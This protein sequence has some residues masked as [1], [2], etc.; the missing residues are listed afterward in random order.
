VTIQGV[1]L[2]ENKITNVD[3]S[4]VH[5]VADTK[6]G[7]SGSCVFNN[8]WMPF[9]LHHASAD[10]DPDDLNPSRYVNEGIR[11]SP[12]AAYLE[13]FILDDPDSR[14]AIEEILSHVNGT[15]AIL[16]HWGALGRGGSNSTPA[17]ETLV[18]IYKG[19]AGDIDVGF[20]NIEWFNLHYHEK[21]QRVADVLVKMNLDIWA[22][23]ET[24]AEA[25]RALADYLRD[26]YHLDFG[27]DFSEPDAPNDKQTTAV[28]W[29][30][31]TVEGRKEQWPDE[32][33]EWFDVHS[34][35]FDDLNLEAVDGK[36]FDRYSAFFRF[37]NKGG[38]DFDFYLVPLHLKAKGEGQKRRRMAAAILGAAVSAMIE[39]YGADHD[40]V[41]GGD[42]DAPLA[43]K[44]FSKLIFG[45]MV[46][47]SAGNEEDGAFSYVKGPQSLIDHIFLSP[48]L[49]QV[50]GGKDF[51]IVA[52]DKQIPHYLTS[53]SDHRAVLVR[54]SINSYQPNEAK[55]NYERR[56]K[57]AGVI[58]R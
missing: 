42:F 49:A 53:L 9:A 52:R 35:D 26:V 8:S 16:G 24:S 13:K 3:E 39:K 21:L 32:I 47:L 58:A 5:Y 11:F 46:P 31:K 57:T 10:N 48:N 29:N 43:S 37:S 14:D 30:R 44:D 54:L 28:I 41:I 27:C 25:T 6:P 7:S 22:F 12:I 17:V 55:R 38:D 51:F 2:Q 20:W 19:E 50:Y 1:T 34:E 40:W 23:E 45:G 18:N 4:L 56:K 36:V 33:D 15:D